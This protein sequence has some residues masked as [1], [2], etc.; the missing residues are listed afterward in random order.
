VK[1]ESEDSHDL[2]EVVLVDDCVDAMT[3][4]KFDNNCLYHI[5]GFVT[6][7]VS[8]TVKREDCNLTLYEKHAG[9]SRFRSLCLSKQK[10]RVVCCILLKVFSELPQRQKKLLTNQE[11]ADS[12]S[13]SLTVACRLTGVDRYCNRSANSQLHL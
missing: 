8:R 7:S 1:R 13:R 10:R 6:R 9:R 3:H 5:G 2:S 11:L 4:G 12:S